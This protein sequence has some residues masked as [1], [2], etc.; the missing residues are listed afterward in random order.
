MANFEL[1][2]KINGVEQTITTIGGLEKALAETN[3]QLSTIDE[4]SREF[5]S[6]QNQA[7]NLTKVIGA[8]NNDTKKL[9]TTIKQTGADVKNLSQNFTQTAQ[10]AATIGGQSAI[11]DCP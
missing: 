11:T 8:L 9:D 10:A 1:N 7:T 5:K 4:N 6:L 2:V 3:Q